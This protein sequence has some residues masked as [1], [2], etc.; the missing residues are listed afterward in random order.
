MKIYK[1]DEKRFL[2][3]FSSLPIFKA[4]NVLK[5]WVDKWTFSAGFRGKEKY[6]GWWILNWEIE[7]VGCVAAQFQ[8]FMPSVLRSYLVRGQIS[9]D[10]TLF[11]NFLFAVL[12]KRLVIPTFETYILYFRLSSDLGTGR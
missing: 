8:E 2:S 3:S 12:W 9:V 11:C 5:M 1:Q 10:E 4:G 6:S 7:N